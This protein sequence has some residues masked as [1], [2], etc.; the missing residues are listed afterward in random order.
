MYTCLCE[1]EDTHSHINVHIMYIYIHVR[2]QYIIRTH[3]WMYAFVHERED[4]LTHKCIHVNVYIIHI[5]IYIYIYIYNY[6]YHVYMCTPE[7]IQHVHT[8]VYT[9]TRARKNT[10]WIAHEWSWG[11]SGHD[12]HVHIS[13]DESCVCICIDELHISVSDVQQIECISCAACTLYICTWLT[14]NHLCIFAYRVYICISLHWMLVCVTHCD[15]S[16]V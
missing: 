11:K 5:Y 8:N 6:I 7:N 12:S 16:Y 13:H 9:C 15:C 1:R 3:M 14:R 4:A 2:V 10:W